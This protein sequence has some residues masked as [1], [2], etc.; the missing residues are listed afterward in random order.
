MNLIVTYVPNLSLKTPLHFEVTG[1]NRASAIPKQSFALFKNF[2]IF[3]RSLIQVFTEGK[4][5]YFGTPHSKRVL[6]KHTDQCKLCRQYFKY[7]HNLLTN[8]KKFNTTGVQ[9][10]GKKPV[11]NRFYAAQAFAKVLN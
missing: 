11:F 8:S 2:K 4:S 7:D 9:F 6:G 1:A 10:T 5:L 3:C